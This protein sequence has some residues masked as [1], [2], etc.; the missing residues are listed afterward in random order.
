MNKIF[1][2]MFVKHNYQTM[3]KLYGLILLFAVFISSVKPKAQE[4][5]WNAYFG[6]DGADFATDIEQTSDNGYIVAGY[7]ANGNTGNYYVVKIDMF[8]N[9]QWQRNLNKDNYSEKA[10]SIL[11]TADQGFIVIGV[12]TSGNKPWLV[13]LDSDGETLWTSAWTDNPD[14]NSA[15]LARGVLLPDQRIVIIGAQGYYGAQPNMFIVSPEGE[16]LEQR[17]LNAVVP[18]GYLSGTFVNHIEP[19][20]D[21][22]F[23][24]TGSAGSGTASRAF[25]WKFDQ[26]A[27]SSWTAHYTGQNAWMRIAESVKQLSNGG[28]ILSGSVGP[29]TNESCAI[30]TD[31]Q[32]NLV[33]FRNY[34]DTI[35]TQATDIIE[36]QNGQFLMTEKRFE[37]VGTTFYQSALLTIDAEG[38]LISRNMIMAS[39]SSTTIT[40]MR[41]TND[42]GFVM[43]GEINEYL[44]MNEQ[45]LFVLKSDALGNISGAMLDYVWPGDVNYDGTVDM[46]DLMILG[47]T[48]GA[49]GPSRV[50]A[51]IGWFPQYVTDWADTVVSGVNYKHADTDGNGIV[52]ILDTLA[53]SVNYGL[54]RTVG[55]KSASALSGFDLFISND[56]LMISEGKYIQIPVRLGTAINPIEGIYGLRFSI[57]TSS[58]LIETESVAIDFS[59]SWL[60]QLNANLWSA[61]KVFADHH[62]VDFGLTRNNHQQVSGF[63]IIGMLSFTLNEPLEPGASLTTDISF[64]NFKATNFDL[65]NLDLYSDTFEIVIINTI[66]SNQEMSAGF[67]QKLSPNP[68]SKGNLLSI[69][70]ASEI[71][72]VEVVNAHGIKMMEILIRNQQ[73][74]SF[75]VPETPGIYF[76]RL[77]NK[78]GDFSI[79]R[80]IVY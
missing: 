4:F 63:G 80:F 3:K 79:K 66:T 9:L 45:D 24:L 21:G 73:E 20:D 46:D 71:V 69:T 65:E 5:P 10:Y 62:S 37:G 18:P 56:E 16:L 76:V 50:N 47:V 33:W 39:D 68:V 60:G 8:G 17:I 43:A 49:S 61:K 70:N 6:S 52:D 48:A 31:A 13:K 26:N 77:H 54:S 75:S 40:R 44:W 58:E 7:G 14:L 55:M 23:I 42:G 35:Y 22:G 57:E 30:R 41:N 1:F 51:S 11:E 67:Q 64:R 59:E 29:N 38:N 15:L 36:W 28:Y 78:N 2:D 32:G 25:L 72:K 53:I 27:D 19:T 12:A 34:P 74:I